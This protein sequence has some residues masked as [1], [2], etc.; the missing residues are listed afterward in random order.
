MA[1]DVGKLNKH[2]GE[3]TYAVIHLI[4]TFGAVAGSFS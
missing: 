1:V 4:G 2:L 3:I